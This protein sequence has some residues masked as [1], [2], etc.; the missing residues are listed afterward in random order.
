MAG[1]AGT[2]R[3]IGIAG[4]LRRGS[5][6]AALLRA[7]AERAPAGTEVEIATIAGIP[8]YNA[9]VEREQGVPEPVVALQQRIASADGLI[10]ATPEYNNSLP[11]VLKNAIDWLTRPPAEGLRIFG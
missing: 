6:N 2:L 9:D 3:L 4:S 7:A 5:Y 11:G 10:I 8:L 1:S